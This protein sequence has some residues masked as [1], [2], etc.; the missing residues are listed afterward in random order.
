MAVEA[1]QATEA[2]GF[3]MLLEINPQPTIQNQLLKA[4]TVKIRS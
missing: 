4:A 2:S 1:T 3:S